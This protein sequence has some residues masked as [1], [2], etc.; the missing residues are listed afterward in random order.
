MVYV[1][2]VI[3]I[4]NQPIEWRLARKI[5]RDLSRTDRW[6]FS[7]KAGVKGVRAIAGDHGFRYSDDGSFECESEFQGV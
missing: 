5:D 2:V 7:L 6:S 1:V 3:V 4:L